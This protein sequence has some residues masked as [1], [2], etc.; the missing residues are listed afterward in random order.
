MS[1]DEFDIESRAERWKEE[2][3]SECARR[4]IRLEKEYTHIIYGEYYHFETT[5]N[6]NAITERTLA[7]KTIVLYVEAMKGSGKTGRDL[8][9]LFL[10]VLIHE[11]FHAVHATLCEQ[12]ASG[13]W[14]NCEKYEIIIESL[15]DAFTYYFAKQILR[16][17]NLAKEK[18]DGWHRRNILVYPYSGAKELVTPMHSGVPMHRFYHLLSYLKG[19]C[20]DDIRCESILRR[21]G[22][23]L[24]ARYFDVSLISL[25]KAEADLLCEYFRFN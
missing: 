16:D 19:G 7:E 23:S 3:F 18:F 5:I 17:D 20:G 1:N 24:I 8:A 9:N 2:L 4:E 25:R 13:T 21:Q 6:K 14:L 12:I 22:L 10:S 11:S 15:A